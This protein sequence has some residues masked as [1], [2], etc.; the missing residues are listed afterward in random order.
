MADILGQQGAEAIGA[1]PRLPS[2]KGTPDQQMASMQAAQA[3]IAAKRKAAGEEYNKGLSEVQKKKDAAA[4][5]MKGTLEAGQNHGEEP[6]KAKFSPT[7]IQ[8]S[9]GWL[10]V[11]AAFSGLASRQPL[12]ASMNAMAGLVEGAKAGDDASFQKAHVEFQE[13]MQKYIEQEKRYHDD[14]QNIV[15]SKKMTMTE[16]VEAARLLAVQY[17]NKMGEA[18]A[19]GTDMASVILHGDKGRQAL[20]KAQ[21]MAQKERHYKE[22]H[23]QTMKLKQEVGKLANTRMEELSK[24]GLKGLPAEQAAQERDQIEKNFRASIIASYAAYG[25]EPPPALTA[26]APSNVPPKEP[27]IWDRVSSMFSGGGAPAAA[28]APDAPATFE[29]EDDV[30]AAYS[31]GKLTKPQA[32]Q[33]LKEKFGHAD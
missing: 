5:D 13:N 31:A 12:T 29:S 1:T 24:V 7:D 9:M 3:P 22:Q 18:A 6:E 21:E 17:Q 4:A 32:V 10:M 25:I 20:Q 30:K 8:K 23:D 33:I 11:A 15:D 28:G 2:L 19:E 26:A 27:G 16:Q 14:F